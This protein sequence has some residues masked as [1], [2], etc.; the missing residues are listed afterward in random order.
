MAAGDGPEREARKVV[1][2]LFCDVVGSTALGERLDPEDFTEVVG[3]AVARM[4]GA[5]EELGG[6]VVEL[7]GDGLLALFGAP[8]AHEDDPERAVR[9]GLRIVAAMQAYGSELARE[10][11]IEGFAVRVGIETGLAVL[12]Q[13]GAGRKVEYSAMGDALNTAARLQ[14]AAEAGTVLVGERTQRAVA[15]V[16]EWAPPRELRLKGKAQAV[17]AFAAAGVREPAGA[18]VGAGGEAPMIGRDAELAA[19]EEVLAGVAEGRGGLL[20]VTGEAGIGKSRLL[21]ELHGAF[22]ARAGEPAG[23]WLHAR[24]AS[25][26]ESVPYVPVG[27]LLLDWLRQR[28]A[29]G[30]PAEQLRAA[31][32]EALG[33]QARR[34]VPFLAA[35]FDDAP[36]AADLAPEGVQ[37]RTFAAV[38]SLFGALAARGPLVVAVDDVHWA[39][40]TTLDLLEALLELTEESALTIVLSARPERDHGSWALRELALRELPHRAREVSLAMLDERTDR[41]L[42][43]ALVGG[44]AL[45][46]ELERRVLARAEGN[47]FYLEETVRSLVE[48]G[49]L[50]RDGERW[51]LD[52]DARIDVPDTVEK[53]VLSRIDRLEGEAHDVLSAAAVL[54]RQF[55][56]PVLERVTGDGDVKAALRELQRLELVR[57]GRRWPVPE[58]RFRHSLI[59]EA[60]YGAMLRRRRQDLHRRAAA[61]IAE[62]HGDR[63]DERAGVLARH[64]HEAGEFEAAFD[65][66]RRAAAGAL[67]L[68]AHEEALEHLDG[69]LAA[70]AALGRGPEVDEVRRVHF[71]RAAVRF[72]SLED[73][74]GSRADLEVA[75]RAARAAGDRELEVDSLLSLGAALRVDDW[76]RAMERMRDA[77]AVAR[78]AGDPALVVRALSRLAISHANL[79][80]LDVAL[81]AGG[82]AL[83]VAGETGRV[84]HRVAALD[85][86]KLTALMLGDLSRLEA[87]CAELAGRVDEL[88]APGP[89]VY[90]I[91][92]VVYRAWALLESSY[93]PAGAGRWDEAMRRIDEALGLITEAGASTHVTVFFD[94]LARA[95]HARGDLEGALDAAD[96][97]A[98]RARRSGHAEWLSWCEATA[99]WTL[100]DMGRAGA[101]IARLET[102]LDLAVRTASP[103]PET[104][105]LGLL[106]RASLARGDL[107]AAGRAADRGCE[108]LANV[109]A[110]PGG[111]FLYGAHAIAG[112]AAAL[113]ATGRAAEARAVAEPALAAAERSGWAQARAELGLA[114]AE[115]L[116]AAGD[117]SGAEQ[118]R[119][120][121]GEIA[122]AGGLPLLAEAARA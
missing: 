77:V 115:A 95:R 21:R 104:R 7:A 42:L 50:V 62:L 44:D 6:T 55:E 38:S 53:L 19:G 45:P 117:A 101:A 57:E 78:G 51:R 89:G 88:A 98:A 74:E 10:R 26:G 9:A 16:F 37:E 71:D 82:E 59:Q 118:A 103:M 28:G 27:A 3:E 25:Y 70:A 36:A 12:G 69:A 20:F 93:V 2:A 94:T 30:E 81:A 119:E 40:A 122:R 5:V 13:L 24:C 52:G 105:A 80:E 106:A 32:E 8:V 84:E 96:E 34:A 86:L 46:R 79:L 58:F 111:A 47:P 83:R 41:A 67:G 87:L 73:F 54:G 60:V 31:C 1:T 33:A 11:A 64:H 92:P 113:A 76:Q 108:R 65:F 102:A 4:V 100:L 22:R 18:P 109:T 66:H 116:A 35:L 15:E 75:L 14:A 112:V 61:A 107:E 68:Y 97:G 120:R 91:A 39:D 90:H 48:S 56:L 114:L 29:R 23:L 72:D 63:L 110:P 99:G 17:R 121:A 43:E 49:A 85:A